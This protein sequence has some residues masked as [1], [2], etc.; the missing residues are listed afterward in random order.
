MAFRDQVDA[1]RH[2]RHTLGHL[3]LTQMPRGPPRVS[4][5]NGAATEAVS[6]SESESTGWP[7]VTAAAQLVVA[8]QARVWRCLL[9]VAGILGSPQA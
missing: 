3:Q 7:S 9:I 4:S 6:R 5:V 1:G 2:V 8:G